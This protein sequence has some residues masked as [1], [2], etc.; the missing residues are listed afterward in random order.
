MRETRNTPGSDLEQALKLLER[1]L[2]LLDR[3]GGCAAPGARLQS[4]IDSIQEL[5]G[6]PSHN[7]M[8]H[9]ETK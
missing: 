8:D 1:A 6:A 2:N 3:V 4:V 5:R 7:S 9:L